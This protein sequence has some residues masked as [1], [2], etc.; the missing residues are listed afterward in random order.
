MAG[1]ITTL[2]CRY[3]G[4]IIAQLFV[5]CGMLRAINPP[6]SVA[7]PPRVRCLFVFKE[8]SKEHSVSIK[9]LVGGINLLPLLI[10]YALVGLYN[11]VVVWSETGKL[12][13]P[14]RCKR[15]VETTGCSLSVVPF[16][17]C[18]YTTV[19]IQHSDWKVRCTVMQPLSPGTRISA[20]LYGTCVRSIDRRKQPAK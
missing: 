8:V 6:C 13:I 12:G 18:L 9:Y 20:T 3:S 15:V 1:S 14:S 16:S 4:T 10:L 7:S 17:S 2:Y 5:Q 19:E 11:T